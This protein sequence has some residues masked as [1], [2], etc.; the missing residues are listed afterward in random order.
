MQKN[1]VLLFFFCL[2]F[3]WL[4]CSKKE[5]T[6]AVASWNGIE[7]SKEIFTKQYINYTSIAPVRDSFEERKRFATELLK[8]AALARH[9]SSFGLDSASYVTQQVQ[10]TREISLAKEFVRKQIEPLVNQ[11]DDEE[12]RAAFRRKNTEIELQQIFSPNKQGIEDYYSRLRKGEDFETLAAESMQAVGE[13]VTSLNM[14]WVSWDQM[15][16]E[17]EKAAFNLE[18][19]QYTQPVSSLVGWHIFKATNKKETFFADATTFENDK[20]SLGFA[21]YRRRFEEKSSQYVDSVR[22]QNEL[23]VYNQNLKQ[24]WEFLEPSVASTNPTSIPAIVSLRAD[25]YSSEELP[26][27]TPVA[28]L[29]GEVFTVQEFL[30]RLSTVPNYMINPNLRLALETTISD[31][32][33]ASKGLEAGLENEQEVVVTTKIAEI[34]ALNNYLTTVVADT[35]NPF[36]ILSRWYSIWQNEFIDSRIA[37]YRAYVFEDSVMAWDAIRF[38]NQNGSLNQMIARFEGEFNVENKEISTTVDARHPVFNFP[39]RSE[40]PNRVWGP[41]KE[42]NGWSVVQVLDFKT[43][44]RDRNQVQEELLSK[45]KQRIPEVVQTE[46]LQQIGFDPQEITFNEELLRSALPSFF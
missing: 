35:L 38:T 23:I 41:I 44:Y 5:E 43:N 30:D 36:R 37:N 14:G 33:F 16:L 7:L 17:P 15:G 34:N 12:V 31:K 32:F 3:T 4:S 2:L 11:P 42:E 24:L 28:V 8:R 39:L 18:I 21:V 46:L 9:A 13:P 40:Y 19:G 29:S 10:R 27:D 22:R 1:S 45:I 26:P 25:Q 6:S 20:E